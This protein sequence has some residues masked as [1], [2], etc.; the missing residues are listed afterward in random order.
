MV[1]EVDLVSYLPPF[2]AEYGE[3]K[4]A[5]TAENPEFMLLR[6]G[7]ERVLKNAFIE[8]AD[9]YGIARFE[10]LL[11]ILPS[12]EDDLESRRKRLQA[13]WVSSLPY[14]ER[15]FLRKLTAVCGGD[16]FTFAK[17]YDEYRIELKVNFESF[18]Q[19]EETERLI[20]LMIPANIIVKMKNEILC[21]SESRLGVYSGIRVTERLCATNDFK[22]KV[23]VKAASGVSGAVIQTMRASIS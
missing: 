8:T 23:T 15:A 7:K 6:D 16:N 5:L 19:V 17:F 1:R 22:E 13:R 21:R 18:G 2:M 20:D 11:N 9:E 14:T 4:A 12:A 3:I 10:K